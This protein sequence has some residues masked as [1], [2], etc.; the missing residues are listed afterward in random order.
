MICETKGIKQRVTLRNKLLSEIKPVKFPF[1]LRSYSLLLVYLNSTYLLKLYLYY[2]MP[3]YT[4]TVILE[5]YD[6]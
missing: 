3:L 5:K 1:I 2:V 4:K 6:N